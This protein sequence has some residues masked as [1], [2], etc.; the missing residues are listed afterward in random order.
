[1]GQPTDI[2][3][4]GTT[5]CNEEIVAPKKRSPPMCAKCQKEEA[6]P[7]RRRRA[8]GEGPAPMSAAKQ[9]SLLRCQEVKKLEL[10]YYKLKERLGT[11]RLKELSDGLEPD[12]LKEKKTLEKRGVELIPI[13]TDIQARRQERALRKRTTLQRF[14]IIQEEEQHEEVAADPNTTADESVVVEPPS[15]SEKPV[16]E[17]AE[18][19]ELFANADSQLE[20][21]STSE[22][23]TAFD[24]VKLEEEDL[25]PVKVHP[26]STAGL[27]SKRKR[28]DLKASVAPAVK[29]I[30]IVKPLK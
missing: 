27:L 6:V 29:R 1:M 23:D 8:P 14:T 28:T 24:K 7:R 20:T 19:N 10:E 4:G 2:E 5:S 17:D 18:L 22:L 21:S 25:A 26:K 9:A 12:E 16:M 30:R 13:W 15:D 11:L 3:M